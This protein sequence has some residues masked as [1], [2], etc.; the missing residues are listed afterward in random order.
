MKPRTSLVFLFFI[1]SL[2]G[3]C[4]ASYKVGLGNDM[5]SMGISENGD[6]LLTWSAYYS[7]DI[8]EWSVIESDYFCFTNRGTGSGDRFESSRY[9]VLN[10]RYGVHVGFDTD[11]FPVY[12]G[13]KIAFG[14]SLSGNLG[15]QQIQNLI[16]SGLG[17]KRAVLEYKPAE[18]GVC[19]AITADIF[20]GWSNG[21]FSI[22]GGFG[23]SSE[24]NLRISTF[25]AEAGLH[26]R[27][28]KGEFAAGWRFVSGT[29][30][31]ATL[32]ADAIKGF[33]FGFSYDLGFLSFN[34]TA[35]PGTWR[36]YGKFTVDIGN[37]F[38]PTWEESVAAMRLSKQMMHGGTSFGVCNVRH[39][40]ADKLSLG[41]RALYSS[42]FPNK[43]H[44]DTET[45]RIMRNYGIWFAEVSYL[46]CP[47]RSRWINYDV[48]LDV[49]FSHWRI[50]KVTNVSPENSG[51]SVLA[52]EWFPA[53]GIDGSVLLFPDGFVVFGK[54][55][56]KI[57]L[58]VGI[59]WFP[60]RLESVLKK[61]MMH[62]NW[63]MTAVVPYVGMGVQF[64]F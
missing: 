40:I 27:G 38:D 39:M 20:G 35:N 2:P 53:V 41:I 61:D 45:Y 51:D 63:K 49:G 16:H 19:P 43:G 55:T 8:T 6:D 24:T 3:I 9:D 5:W 17:I 54:T 22:N 48:S 1:V 34:Y 56:V 59:E 25:H 30:T 64:G 52:D 46:I 21:L 23:F 62:D 13:T 47:D 7:E 11:Y 4:F 32:Y 57:V 28:V 50:E 42:G 44:A 58:S 14:V 12:F 15:G 10:I 29:G 31:I 26:H 37:L 36:G 18:I 33:Y 60:S